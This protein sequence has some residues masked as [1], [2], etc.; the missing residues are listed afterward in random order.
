MAEKQHINVSHEDPKEE[1]KSRHHQR[2]AFHIASEVLMSALAFWGPSLSV[3]TRFLEEPVLLLGEVSSFHS[4]SIL[5]IDFL[6]VMI[7]LG[8]SNLQLVITIWRR[9][10][11]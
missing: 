11:I 5:Q 10:H 3:G 2:P 9:P 1:K 6:Q 4:R 8:S 7:R